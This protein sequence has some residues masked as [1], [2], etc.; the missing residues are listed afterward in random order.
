[1]KLLPSFLFFNGDMFGLELV[2]FINH[3]FPCINGNFE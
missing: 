1:M 2:S 3:V